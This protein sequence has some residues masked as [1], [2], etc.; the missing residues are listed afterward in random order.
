M[1]HAGSWRFSATGPAMGPARGHSSAG[2]CGDRTGSAL[3]CG[4]RERFR[5]N[6]GACGAGRER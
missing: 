1:V 5:D 6:P 4:V 3:S 2:I